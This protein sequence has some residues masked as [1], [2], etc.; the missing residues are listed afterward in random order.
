MTMRGCKPCYCCYAVRQ[1]E[2]RA[3]KNSNLEAATDQTLGRVQGGLW[4]GDRL[5][6]RHEPDQSRPIRLQ[7][8]KRRKKR[9]SRARAP[10]G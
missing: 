8:K 10:K 6:L 1:I 5:P 4:V 7:D 3:N 9:K 2:C